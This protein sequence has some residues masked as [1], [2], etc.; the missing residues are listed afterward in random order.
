MSGGVY[1]ERPKPDEHFFGKSED[2]KVL[3]HVGKALGLKGQP[4]LPATTLDRGTNENRRTNVGHQ[5]H[6]SKPTAWGGWRTE[7]VSRPARVPGPRPR[8]FPGP[9]A[10]GRRLDVDRTSG[11][12]AR[13]SHFRASGGKGGLTE[14][15]C[16]DANVGRNRPV[17]R[18]R[19][20]DHKQYVARYGEDMPEVRNWVVAGGIKVETIIYISSCW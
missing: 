11:S 7:P 9:T 6:A 4:K 8:S 12:E 2:E 17:P 5:P 20:I 14:N 19:V 15:H 16:T 1:M 3:P 10:A 13:R 18:D